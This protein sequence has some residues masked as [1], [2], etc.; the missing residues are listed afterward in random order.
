MQTYLGEMYHPLLQS[1]IDL[2]NTTTPNKFHI[3][4]NA[5]IPM[6]DYPL[7]L[8]IDLWKIT[9]PNKFHILK[10]A[11]IPSLDLPPFN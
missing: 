7:Q 1:T 8:T 10:N 6:A 5:H 4:K 11:H 9:T 2:W 3:E